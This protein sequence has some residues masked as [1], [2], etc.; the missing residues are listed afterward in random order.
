ME[1]NARAHTAE[2]GK[3]NF[4]KFFQ[5]LINKYLLKTYCVTGLALASEEKE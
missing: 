3:N 4:E 2:G 5:S 1:R